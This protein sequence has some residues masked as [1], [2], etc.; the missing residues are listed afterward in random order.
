ME[1]RKNLI[2]LIKFS[3][4]VTDL[5]GLLKKKNFLTQNRPFYTKKIVESVNQLRGIFP[6]EIPLKC[7]DIGCG[8]WSYFE[9][10]PQIHHFI[11][12]FGIDTSYEELKVNSFV[13]NKIVFDCCNKDYESTL[14]EYKNYF[15]LVI[16]HDFLEH[17]EDPTTTHSLIN[18]L[19]KPDGIAIHSYPSLF[20]P[21]LTLAHFI[22]SGLAKKILYKIEPVRKDSGKFKTYYRK[23]RSFS[24]DLKKW[25]NGLG[26]SV[27]D[28]R[29]FYGTTYLFAI[30][31]LQ[32]ILNIFYLL[33]LKLRLDFFCSYS[34]IVLKK[35]NS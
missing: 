34:V 24:S 30:P 4:K 16:T 1:K 23:C 21:V 7:V 3:E 14:K 18:F 27:I 15:H 32:M 8:K 10:I 25:Y 29:N 26:F 28:F 13:K 5:M 11:E 19:L 12:I 35:T 17:T 31:P 22:P 33:I 6:E 9:S 2:K 20:D